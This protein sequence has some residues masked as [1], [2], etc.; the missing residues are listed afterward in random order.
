MTQISASM[1]KELREKTGLGMMDCK[2]ALEQSSGNIDLAIENLRKNSVL[3]AEKKASRTAVEGIIKV[4]ID[5]TS[6][7]AVLV[8]INCETDFVSKD[9]NFLNFSE[10]VMET[11]ILHMDD[12][13]L[14]KEVNSQLEESRKELVQKIGENVVIRNIRILEGGVVNFYI[15]SN[16]KVAA[17]VSLE[18]GSEEIAK[19]IAMHVVASN[20]LALKPEDLP[21]DFIKKEKEIIKSQVEKEEKPQEIIEKM[22]T[23]KLSKRV[24][25]VSLLKQPY[26]KDPD[27]LIEVFLNNSNAVIKSFVRL[28]VGE[29]IEIEKSDFA[30]EVK[31][32]IENR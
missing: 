23:G 14:L 20:P 29:G 31:S 26:V 22:F 8:E 7:N 13:D 2:K 1:V 9:E 6:K 11:S 4:K 5:P 28:E 17:A 3:D 25:E 12:K 21:E 10:E 16:K 32:Q 19:D 15:H 24:G 18:Q 30:A 27:Q